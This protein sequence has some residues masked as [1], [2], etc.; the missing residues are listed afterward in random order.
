MPHRQGD[1][2][3]IPMSVDK[4]YEARPRWASSP[5]GRHEGEIK[6]TRPVPELSYDCRA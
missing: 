1:P 3:L 5:L 2:H 6:E 4:I